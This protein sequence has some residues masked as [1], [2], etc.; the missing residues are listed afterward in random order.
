[1]FLKAEAHCTSTAGIEIRSGHTVH[2][3]AVPFP[4]LAVHPDMDNSAVNKAWTEELKNHD[5]ITVRELY[6]EYPDG[7]IDAEKER[8]LC[9][10]DR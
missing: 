2:T 4:V 9:E 7:K 5:E 8:Q 1:M 3:A 6:K 10:L